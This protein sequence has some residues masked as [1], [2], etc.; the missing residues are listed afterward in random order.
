LFN[1]AAWGPSYPRSRLY[2]GQSLESDDHISD[3]AGELC[4]CLPVVVSLHLACRRSGSRPAAV[5]SGKID[6]QHLPRGEDIQG[7]P[8]ALEGLEQLG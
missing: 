1:P 4:A 3:H 5:G 8:F 6:G 2:V 7:R